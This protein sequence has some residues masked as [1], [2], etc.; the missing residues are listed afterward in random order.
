MA[1]TIND[2]VHHLAKRA[3]QGVTTRVIEVSRKAYLALDDRAA[4][5]ASISIYGPQGNVLI[6]P[7]DALFEDDEHYWEDDPRGAADV[8]AE[9]WRC[10]LCGFLWRGSDPLDFPHHGC[11]ETAPTPTGIEAEVCAD[12]AKRQQLGVKKYGQT[13]ADNHAELR[14]RLQHLYEEQLDAAVYTKW[15]I[16]KLEGE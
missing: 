7:N 10:R 15:A 4:S 6:R 2:F 1:K 13:L 3:D 12:I 8:Q 11:G 9:S 5:A 16:K 14:E